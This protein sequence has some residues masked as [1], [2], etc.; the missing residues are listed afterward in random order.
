VAH[1][2]QLM[3]PVL[4]SEEVQRTVKTEDSLER[5]LRTFLG[6][7]PDVPPALAD[8]LPA[9][10]EGVPGVVILQ[11]RTPEVRKRL[12][13][14]GYVRQHRFAV[15]PS[16]KQARWLLPLTGEAGSLDGFELYKPFSTYARMMKALVLLTRAT[17]W[18]GWVQHEVLLASRSLLPIERLASEVTGEDQFIFTLSLG[19]PG[20]F[21][22]LTVQVM[23]PD[24]V[25]LGYVKM[26]LTDAAGERLSNEAEFLQMLSEF[27]SM[28][29]HI[30]RLLFGGPWNGSTIL[31]ESPLE[32]SAGPVRFTK[33]HKE[34]LAS[35]H[36]CCTSVLPGQKLV[37][38]AAPTWES[39]APRMGTRW[40]GLGR[41]ALRIA[42]RELYGTL[43]PC[44]IHHGDFTP[45]NLR[46]HQG[47]LFVFDWES[48]T[49]GEPTLWDQFHFIA[50][51]EC[52]LKATHETQNDAGIREQHRALY[53]L[54]LLTSTAQLTEEKAEQKTIDYREKQ[55]SRYISG[56][57]AA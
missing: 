52:L 19:T 42:E 40:Q 33:L 13:S 35:L 32:G 48:A 9:A 29:P 5:A 22:K 53:L 47:R 20:T 18:E 11:S 12:A 51:T 38:R 3:N 46:A 50:Q 15:L 45:W 1:G 7:A 10:C 26:P 36:S 57:A 56:A 27:P 16:R 44:G 39:V 41:E 8:Q 34:F 14:E 6:W 28:R 49:W 30:P 21:Q 2:D 43:V 23:R 24:G 31:F 55:I 17:G 25:I 37:H 54:Y 4:V